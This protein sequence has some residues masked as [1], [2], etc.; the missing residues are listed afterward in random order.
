MQIVKDGPDLYKVVTSSG[1]V[2]IARL[3]YAAA[4]KVIEI[5]KGD[6]CPTKDDGYPHYMDEYYS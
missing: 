2:V 3:G 1:I 5:L 4:A 6:M